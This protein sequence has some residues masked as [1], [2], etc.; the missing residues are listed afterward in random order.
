MFTSSAI[1]GAFHEFALFTGLSAMPT[2][3]YSTF[4]G[5]TVPEG[6]KQ[7]GSSAFEYSSSLTVVNYPSTITTFRNMIYYRCPRT[8]TL[9]IL[10]VTPPTLGD[11]AETL[12]TNGTI[13]V[14]AGSVDAYKSAWTS[15]ASRIQAIP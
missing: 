10:A 7:I 11:G 8:I 15:Y 6:I 5:I 12:P 9:T 14:P 13:Y 4:T 1:T 2:M 3:K